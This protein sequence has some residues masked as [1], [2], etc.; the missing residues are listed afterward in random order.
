MKVV[1]RIRISNSQRRLTQLS[2]K[3]SE[4]QGKAST[5][6]SEH[7]LFSVV[8]LKAVP[9]ALF[10]VVVLLL[11][12][13]LV[14]FWPGEIF[15]SFLPQIMISLAGSVLVYLTVVFWVGISIGFRKMLE[16]IGN[17]T[18]AVCIVS[19]TMGLYVLYD[20]SHLVEV[21]DYSDKGEVIGRG[22]RYGTFNKLYTSEDFVSDTDFIFARGAEIV[23]LQ[24][25]D[26]DE[27]NVLRDILGFE[28]SFISDCNCSADDTEI[29]LI[30]K[31]PI[32]NSEM[33]YEDDNSGAV[34]SVVDV[35]DG[36]RI[37]IYTAHIYVPNGAEIIAKKRDVYAKLANRINGDEL[38]VLM[39]GDFNSTIFS[40]SFRDFKNSIYGT[41]R[42]AYERRWPKCSWYGFG[43]ISCL[44][45]DHVFVSND[46][47]VVDLQI[48]TDT[49]SDHR[50]VVVEI[51]I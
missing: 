40:P 4:A 7:V 28:H 46:A 27:V 47:E 42:G 25:I 5:K 10:L 21:I 20:S 37:A 13:Y 11:L 8:F 23:S 6:K 12:S 15:V 2:E 38:P 17:F 9:I 50:P 14:S 18:I 35:G 44:R 33:I 39:S 16:M 49:Y 45:I 41:A 51:A 32:V 1:L 43:E 24:E 3:R 19:M 30:S 26:E 34:R 36:E 22:L 31:Y 29:A 48:G